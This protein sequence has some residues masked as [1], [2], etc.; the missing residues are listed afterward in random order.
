MQTS[1]SQIAEGVAVADRAV[2]PSMPPLSRIHSILGK[3][4]TMH[5][6]AVKQIVAQLEA[7]LDNGL[8]GAPQLHACVLRDGWLPI[9]S[10]LNYS[11]LG[12]T[13]WPY[14]GVGVVGDCLMARPSKSI[15]LSGDGA[16]VRAKPLRVLVRDALE[17]LFS[18]ANYHRDVHLQL[19]AEQDGYTPLDALVRTYEPVRALL[20]PAP[21]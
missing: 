7:L 2:L 1:A 14:G 21:A 15:E 5:D 11:P 3:N 4:V 8:A 6:G 12:Q 20:A 17:R 13:V 19:L 9:A 16:C 18:D 10:V